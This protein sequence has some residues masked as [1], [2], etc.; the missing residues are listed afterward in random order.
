MR[1][2]RWI[3]TQVLP[4]S[5]NQWMDN[6]QKRLYKIQCYA[7]GNWEHSVA[8]ASTA[9]TAI[10]LTGSAA[11]QDVAMPQMGRITGIG[12]TCSDPISAG[13][14][15][16]DVTINSIKQSLECVIDTDDPYSQVAVPNNAVNTELLEFDVGDLIGVEVKFT[17]ITDV[18]IINV[19]VFVI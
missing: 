14:I 5:I 2:P 18:Y 3:P 9:Y 12:M 16:V 1:I 17:G 4:S 11:A 15:T 19:T 6:L 10:D 13:S 8:K 7:C